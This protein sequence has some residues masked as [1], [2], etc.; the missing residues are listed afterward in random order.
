VSLLR[1]LLV[2]DDNLIGMLLSAMLEG[3][4]YEVV[5]IVATEADAVAYAARYE[6]D[7]MIVDMN[8]REGNGA[9]AVARILQSK[10]VPHL[11]MSGTVLESEAAGTVVLQKPFLEKDLVQAIQRTLERSVES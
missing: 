5:A 10:P 7:L 1:I 8:L 2:E 9:S 3:M 4:D 6:L 11:F